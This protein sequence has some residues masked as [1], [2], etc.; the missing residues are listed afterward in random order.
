M[1]K[2]VL[3]FGV[4][5]FLLLVLFQLSKY[6]LLLNRLQSELFIAL[7]AGL[8]LLFGFLTSRLV[9]KRKEQVIIEKTIE[10]PTVIDEK[11]VREL[12]ISPREY[13]V[14]QEIAQGL[15]NQ[16]I[17][18]KLFISETTVK[19][20]VSSLLMKLDARRRTQAVNHAKKMGII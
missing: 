6:S 9:F 19:S 13:E 20:H 10:A 11:K 5:A 8:F 17:A 4:L 12:G 15:S 3:Q 16:E 14:L 1:R 7:F 18:D 2:I